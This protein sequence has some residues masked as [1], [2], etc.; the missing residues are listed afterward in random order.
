MNVN[1]WRLKPNYYPSQTP[2]RLIEKARVLTNY[3]Y[4][5]LMW[6]NNEVLVEVCTD[7]ESEFDNRIKAWKK[8][9]YV[10]YPKDEARFFIKYGKEVNSLK[11]V[12]FPY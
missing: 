5:L 12:Y 3:R 9:N 2:H 11:E 7:V 10:T 4:L 6:L 1:S 8:L